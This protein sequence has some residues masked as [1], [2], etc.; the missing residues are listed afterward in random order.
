[1]IKTLKSLFTG[2]KFHGNRITANSF[3]A[4]VKKAR[5]KTALANLLA[6]VR[7]GCSN[8]KT[9]KRRMTLL[10]AKTA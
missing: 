3:A 2:N 10:A 1:M 7:E 4:R 8:P 5:S 6:T 9:V